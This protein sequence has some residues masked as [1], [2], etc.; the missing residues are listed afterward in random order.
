MSA[1]ES[2][3]DDIG[4]SQVGE[5]EPALTDG[6]VGAPTEP[7][8]DDVSALEPHQPEHPWQRQPGESSRAFGRFCEYRDLGPKRSLSRLRGPHTGEDGW[9]RR[10]LED[11]CE[12][13]NW[14]PRAAAWDEEQDR[15][16]RLAQLE[17]ITE[18]AERQARDG[19]DMQKLARGAMAKWV[20][21]D[22]ATG[23]L[24]LA[25]DLSPVEACRLYLAG[26]QVERLARGEPTAVTE[27]RM[28]REAEYDEERIAAGVAFALARAAAD[29]PGMGGGGP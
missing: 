28:G 26:V 27:E 7:T 23:Q 24:A 20:K 1:N 4:E 5:V 10:A 2:Q 18:M 19:A 14:P 29:G 11:L 12:R 13:W 6:T 3:A 25:R 16:W 15:A 9:S 17:A 8:D 21:T 22:P